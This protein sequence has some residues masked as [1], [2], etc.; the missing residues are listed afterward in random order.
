MGTRIANYIKEYQ[1]YN[2]LVSPLSKVIRC[3]WANPLN[4]DKPDDCY[5]PPHAFDLMCIFFLQMTGRLPVCEF[6][7]QETESRI[8]PQNIHTTQIFGGD[9]EEWQAKKE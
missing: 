9:E 5:L 7:D 8:D 2:Q 4:L 6:V 3:L 1:K